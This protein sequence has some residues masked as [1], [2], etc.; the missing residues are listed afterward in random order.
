MRGWMPVVAIINTKWAI[1]ENGVA[2]GTEYATKAAAVTAA[3]TAAKGG[4]V[5][6]KG[7]NLFGSTKDIGVIKAKLPA[8][9]EN[10]GAVNR[11]G[12]TR[13]DVEGTLEKFGFYDEYTQE[14]LDFDTDAELNMHINRE[15][16]RGANEITEAALQTDLINGAGVIHFCGA[17][18]SDAEVSGE[19]TASE[20]TYK[21]LVKVGIELDKNR[22]PKQ[23]KIIDGSRMIDTRVVNSA[24]ALYIGSELSI[25][26]QKMTDFHTQQAF[27]PV[28]HYANAATLLPGEIGAINDFRIIVV[29]EM[30]YFA[31]KGKAVGTNPG[32]HATGKK[33]DIFPMLVVGDGSFTTIGFQ[34]DG[35]TTKFKITHKKPGYETADRND[36]YGEVG[37]MSIKWYYGCVILRN[38][39]ICLIKTVA[40]T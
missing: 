21:D 22:T 9:T 30:Q 18:T 2:T 13:I 36:P 12:F 27:I 25:T 33:Y 5:V 10:G 19:G 1:Y 14:S 3:D 11:V 40:R 16:L 4:I 29:P 23:T 20:V 39:R 31:G 17:A 38:E 24:R 35:K 37:F 6:Q 8:L 26:I 34:T 32:F 7:G 15:M 28:A